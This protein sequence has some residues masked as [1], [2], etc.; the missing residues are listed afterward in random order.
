M[1]ICNELDA[2]ALRVTWLNN[3]LYHSLVCACSHGLNQMQRG[4]SLYISW[5][6]GDVAFVI[7]PGKQLHTFYQ[8]I[9]NVN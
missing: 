5:I 7:Y 6:G 8:D 2:L 4:L 1:N 9:Y 3:D